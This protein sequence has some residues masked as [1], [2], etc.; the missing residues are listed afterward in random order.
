MGIN[1]NAVGDRVGT[2]AEWAASTLVLAAGERA[3][4]SDTGEVRVGN[5]VDVHSALS[6][7]GREG[8]AVLV[9]GTVTVA[10]TSITAKSI[11]LASCQV[12]GTVTRP[13]GIGV[14]ARSVGVS[15]TL[16]SADATDTSTVGYQ[17]IEK[18]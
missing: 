4:S 14:H 10:D 8:T 5:G 3:V 11:I 13:Q 2:A 7:E 15:F 6:S 1:V 18:A 16:R 12:L 9:G 17:I